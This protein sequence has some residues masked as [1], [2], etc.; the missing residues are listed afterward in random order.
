MLKNHRRTWS[1]RAALQLL[2]SA[3]ITDQPIAELLA[4]GNALVLENEEQEA[5]RPDDYAIALLQGV[6]EHREEI[7]D[8]V[9]SS[10][11]NWAIERMPIMDRYVNV[12]GDEIVSPKTLLVRV[13]TPFSA[14]IE[15]CGGYKSQ[16]D[17]KIL[18]VGGA[19]MG[20]SIPNDDCVVTRT[21]TS[22]V[23]NKKVYYKEEPCI[24]CGTC[25]LSC[26]AHLYPVLVMKAM[27]T[28]PVDRQKIKDLKVL[29][30]MECGLCSYSCTSKIPLTDYMR[31]AKVVA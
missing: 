6:E 17:E 16:E 11:E 14:L 2:Y 13:G 24:R 19:M 31:R 20:S 25:V 9:D 21:V 23:C 8:M 18:L 28:M 12:N 5:A 30:C 1:R 27:K 4:A 7:D 15:A 29:N 22:L 26:P 10:S 3:E